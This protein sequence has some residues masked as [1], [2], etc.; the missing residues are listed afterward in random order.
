M[1]NIILLSNEQQ[2]IHLERFLREKAHNKYTLITTQKYLM[3]LLCNNVTLTNTS[4]NI[5]YIGD[6]VLGV[7]RNMCMQEAIIYFNNINSIKIYENQTMINKLGCKEIHFIDLDAARYISV[8]RDV[9]TQLLYCYHSLNSLIEALDPEQLV[10]LS[11]ETD[12]EKMAKEICHINNIDFFKYHGSRGMLSNGGSNDFIQKK[13]TPLD[14]SLNFSVPMAIIPSLLKARTCLRLL[15]NMKTKNNSS[16]FYSHDTILIYLINIRFLD[17]VIPV[18]KSIQ[19]DGLYHPL[20]LIPEGFSET[21]RFEDL[22]IPFEYVSKYLNGNIIKESVKI[23]DTILNDYRKLMKEE[24]FKKQLYSYG[25]LSLEKFLSKEINQTV[26]FSFDSIINILLMKRIISL[27]GAKGLYMP[28]FSENI[29]KSFALSCSNSDIPS[30]CLH[31]GTVGFG[32][33]Y[34]TVN[35]DILLVA[36][37]H[38]REGFVKCGVS[39]EKIRITGLPIFDYL[40]DNLSN[41]R[42]IEERIRRSLQID[43]KFVIVTY[44][45]QSFS[46]EFGPEERRREIECVYQTI[47]EIDNIFLV[48]KTH[49]TEDS[50]EIYNH[51]AKRIGLK[52]FSIVKSELLLD[53]LLLSSRIVITK[54]STAGFNALIAGCALITLGVNNRS[55]ENNF[56]VDSKVALTAKDPEELRNC[57]KG[58]LENH[59]EVVIP[60][61]RVNKFIERHFFRRGE[62]SVERIKSCIY[63]EFDT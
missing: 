36:G 57:I 14:S 26:I 3:N 20:I 2:I 33:E 6:I 52:Y 5:H 13:L 56:F 62:G 50:Q 38:S 25:E 32:P 44:L 43:S 61:E 54:N 34:G 40:L 29:V 24:G 9:I 16:A 53:D 7:N 39:A 58:V 48:V 59:F 10:T 17:V 37:E 41:I 1:D 4:L 51:L 46:A 45:T 35:S 22:N 42:E 8:H 27:S 18:A 15:K 60:Q 23:Y 19:N 11:P 49:P 47:K 31:R 12:W 55:L 28:H 21:S 63:S 30:I